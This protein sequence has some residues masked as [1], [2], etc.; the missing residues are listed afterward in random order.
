MYMRDGKVDSSLTNQGYL[1]PG[2]P[3]TV[4]G[5][6]LAHKKFGHLPWKDVVMPAVQLA[7]DGFVDLRRRSRAA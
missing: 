1:A 2:V 3:G 7:E 5:L 6:A 4:R